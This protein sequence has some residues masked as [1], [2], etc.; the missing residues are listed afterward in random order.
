MLSPEIT[1]AIQ[2]L[3]IAVRECAHAADVQKLEPNDNHRHNRR[4]WGNAVEE[5]RA[6]LVATIEGAF[7]G[8]RAKYAE[9][10]RQDAAETA[11]TEDGAYA[12]DVGDGQYFR[13]PNGPTVF[14]RIPQPSVHGLLLD[15][16]KVFGISISTG[17]VCSLEPDCPIEHV[18]EP[19]D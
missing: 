11:V 9:K 3:E 19:E 15:A 10:A 14:R 4:E 6:I 16:T 13:L 7:Q 5:K 2:E 8:I 17:N 12:N 1:K 18:D